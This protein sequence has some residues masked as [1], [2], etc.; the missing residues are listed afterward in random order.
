MMNKKTYKTVLIVLVV[1]LQ[2]FGNA[3]VQAQ[4]ITKPKIACPNDVWVNSYNGV[5][6]Y[7]RPELQYPNRSMPLQ[8]TFYYNSSSFNQ[9]FGYGTG[10]SLGYEMR[11]E[12][13]SL[14]IIIIRGDGRKDLFKKYGT[15]F[16]SPAGVFDKLSQEGDKYILA[17][18]YGDKYYLGDTVNPVIEKM[19]DRYGNYL[20]F[21][22]TD[23]LLSAVADNQGRSL[24]FTWNDSL[25]IKTTASFDAQTYTYQ[26]DTLK[27]LVKV[28]NPMGFTTTYG[29]DARGLLNEMIDPN[30]NKTQIFYNG[31]YMVSRVKT[32]LTDKSIRYENDR[33]VIVDYVQSTNQFTTYRWDD[34]GR[35]IEKKGHC[36]GRQQQMEYD[37]DDNVIRRTDANGNVTYYTY[38]MEG[39]MLTATDPL[40]Y[41]VTC[42]YESNF[43][44]M[45]SYTDKK[46]N[47]THYAYDGNGNLVS[48][49][50]PLTN[51]IEF[52]YDSY[53][54]MLTY[55]DA[56]NNTTHFANDNYGNVTAITDAGSRTIGLNYDTRGNVTAITDAMGNITRYEYNKQNL[57]VKLTNALGQ[58]TLISYDRNG[59]RLSITD[60][61]LRKTNYKYSEL[62]DIT[63]VKDP[64]NQPTQY[65]RNA[66][67][68]ITQITDALDGKT[69]LMYDDMDQIE[70][71][72]N[73]ENDT[74]RYFYDTKGNLTG[75]LQQGGSAVQYTYNNNDQVISINDNVG[76][77][78]E[79]IYDANG[80]I[81]TEKDGEGKA[82]HFEYDNLNRLI[83][84]TDPLSFFEEYEYDP[85]N[86]LTKFKHKDGTEENFTY[87]NL[88]Q[89]TEH[90][91]AMN[92]TTHFTYDNNN[93]LSSVTDA[94]NHAT[95]YEY[96]ALKRNTLITF[97][98]NSTKQ[99][100][101]D[102]A[103]NVQKY[104]DNAGNLMT[105]TY[106]ALNRLTQK[107]Y[108][109]NSN[110]QYTYDAL[111]N[112]LTAINTTA[113]VAFTYDHAKRVLS[114]TL[115]GKITAYSYNTTER[116]RN[117]TYPGGRAIQEFYD[118]RNRLSAITEG[119]ETLVTMQY[120][121]NNQLQQRSYSN[122]TGTQF[123]Y[124]DAG[125]L[126]HIIDFPDL[127]D[128]SM[129][130]DPNGNMLYRKDNL[131]PDR[132]ETYAYDN[133]QRLTQFKRGVMAG[134]TIPAPVKSITYGMDALGNRT[135]V[136]EDGTNTNY[137][138]GSMN[139]YTAITGA[140]N[141][142][143]AYDG[144]GNM[145]NDHQHNYTYDYNNRMTGVDNT[146]TATY[147]YDALGR[148]TQKQTA[149]GTLD[150]FYDG[151]RMIEEYTG[152]TAQ[153]NYLYGNWVDDI[154]Q[155]NRD[156][157]DY[158]YHKNHL[159]SVM[160]LS[161]ATGIVAES[162]QYQPYGKPEFYNALQNPMANSALHNDI[163]FTGRQWE[164]ESELYYYRARHLS[165]QMGRFMQYDPLGYVDGM[166]YH[167][168]VGSNPV[169]FIDPYGLKGQECHEGTQ[170]KSFCEKHPIICF[171]GEM[172][173]AKAE[174][175]LFGGYGMCIDISITGG[176]N[177]FDF[178]IG[179]TQGAGLD[180]SF[181]AEIGLNSKTPD[182]YN[183]NITDIARL[184]LGGKLIGSLEYSN[185]PW[186]ESKDV[187]INAGPFYGRRNQWGDMGGGL[188][189]GLGVGGFYGER[190]VITS[191]NI[192]NGVKQLGNG[193]KNGYNNFIHQWAHGFSNSPM[194][195]KNY[196]GF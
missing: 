178:E 128:V 69:R 150:Y 171:F 39:N 177:G 154:L 183:P 31:D 112:M 151:D 139:Q 174:A 85:N 14:G 83:K 97:A 142:T 54:Q 44:Q 130:Y 20:I 118:T 160:A 6:F 63:E 187:T 25:L 21:S 60:P 163:L 152:N 159:G 86:K 78:A 89:L 194:N 116:W 62:N 110:D 55:K 133:L 167:A 13:D 17:G 73:A 95:Q 36:C 43:N 145:L 155:M 50:N 58:N 33:T 107:H 147:K 119:S 26:Y 195:G 80:N 106:D 99:Y 117:I 136:T 165:N 186:S 76:L 185:N 67:S 70:M 32:A 113:T 4:N 87:N 103:G 120:N 179:W 96:D 156:G 61:L 11:Y 98:D 196:I 18:K 111:G 131:Y 41:V 104:K 162:Y 192:N 148:R 46:G 180:V 79:Y 52:T 161:G 109:D 105:Y 68:L 143:P 12:I 94:N 40:G 184:D 153:A 28:I 132:S 164:T 182:P 146:I 57:P 92:N 49:T 88:N 157:N 149:E 66:K 82:T 1:S 193:I 47:T 126:T 38:D 181:G 5:M 8:I 137:T 48:V 191:G 102:A 64:L 93:N 59:N 22:Y 114:E 9:N 51:V 173:E 176:E 169:R 138:A 190:R 34:K 141:A 75:I 19:E 115:N 91:D 129:D 45:T 140:L 122:G 10:W 134:N 101:Y 42:T 71:M 127:S 65:I 3:F 123:T 158:F 100:W 2:L 124:N 37:D 189:V 15:L 108:P 172:I 23:K 84:M 56:K 125:W 27:Q 77:I 168:Y 35:V 16:E 7:Q 170:D 188:G 135:I 53:G 74:I 29:Y 72:I 24:D 175:C 144:N 90:K 30:G 121:A 81:I 166:N